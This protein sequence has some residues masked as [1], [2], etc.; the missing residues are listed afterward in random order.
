M[1]FNA[2]LCPETKGMM[3]MVCDGHLG[4][5]AAHFVEDHFHRT[6]SSLLPSKLPDWDKLRGGS[7][8]EDSESLWSGS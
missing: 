1:S 8:T 6:L 2:L 3:Y 5:D 4:V 7:F